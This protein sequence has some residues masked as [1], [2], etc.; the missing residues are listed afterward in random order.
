MYV[1]SGYFNEYTS[2]YPFVYRK[3]VNATIKGSIPAF[4][5]DKDDE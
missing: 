2:R 1:A 4:G 5:Y 3:G